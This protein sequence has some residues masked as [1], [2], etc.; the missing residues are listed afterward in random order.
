VPSCGTPGVPCRVFITSQTYDGNLG[1]LAGAD[2][3]C[4][5]LAN[6][7][8][9]TQGGT[10]KA[11]LSD[12]EFADSP[13]LRFANTAQTGPYLRVDDA[14]TVIASGWA[15]LTDT[16][17]QAT[18]STDELGQPIGDPALVWSNTGTGGFPRSASNCEGWSILANDEF[19]GIGTATF[20]DFHWTD[21]GAVSCDTPSRLYC[22]EQG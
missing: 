19:G 20:T 14:A 22:F 2:A 18:I 4:Q 12:F 21:N 15:D 1:G 16:E 11:W 17:L 5:A 3:R 8:P 6:A 10:Y 9:R 13:A 7:S